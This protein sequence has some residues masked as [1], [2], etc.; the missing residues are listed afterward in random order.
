MLCD[1]HAIRR[2]RLACE[3]SHDLGSRKPSVVEFSKQA[4]LPFDQVVREFF[5][6]VADVIEF[7]EPHHVAVQAQNA[8]HPREIPIG[9]CPVEWQGGNQ[10]V[11]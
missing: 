1:E 9:E 8:V 4:I 10:R 7:D 2:I 3:C 5:D 11:V 6:D